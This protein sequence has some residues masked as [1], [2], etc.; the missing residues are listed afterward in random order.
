[1]DKVT[2][3]AQPRTAD[4]SKAAADVRRAGQVP[5]V[6]YGKGIETVAITVC[7]KE[8]GRVIKA[9]G[10]KAEVEIAIEGGA[11]TTARIQELQRGK[12]TRDL[13][14]L[15]FKAVAE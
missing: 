11:T 5:A 7:A 1:M 3:S 10:V 15:D 12:V 14:H 9:N 4:G 6:L 2:V 8:M 13:L